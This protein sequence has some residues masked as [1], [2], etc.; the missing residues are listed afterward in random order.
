MVRDIC[1]KF[2]MQGALDKIDW[3]PLPAVVCTGEAV[4]AAMRMKEMLGE[5]YQLDNEPLRQTLMYARRSW[6]LCGM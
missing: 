6:K 5:E 1:N 2:N 4:L 3:V